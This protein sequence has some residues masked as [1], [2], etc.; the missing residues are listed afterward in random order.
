MN[1]RDITLLFSTRIVRLF[2]YGFL[3]VVLVLYLIQV[4]LSEAQVGLLITLTLAGDAAI[5][6]WLTTNADRLGRKR[7]LI[8][9]ALLMIFAGVIFL[10]TDNIILLIAAAII[11]VLSPSGNEIGPFLSI[12]QASLT[13]L[14]PDEKRTQSFAWYNLAGSVATAF[15]ALIGGGLA[16]LLQGRY[17]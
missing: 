15:G 8:T 10:I 9:S 2:A 16:Q 1:R 11:G 4:G 12:E 7:I 3:S 13:Q 6:L 17:R 14:L 5:S